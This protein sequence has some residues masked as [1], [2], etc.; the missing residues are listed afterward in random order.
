MKNIILI[1]ALAFSFFNASAQHRKILLLHGNLHPGNGEVLPSAAVG[2]KDGKII[3]LKNSLAFTYDKADWDT[4][5]DLNGKHL[6]PGFVAPN[7]TLGITEI[8]AV[9]STRDF[10]EVGQFNP[11]IRSQVA[12]NVESDVIST[13]RTNGILLCQS[14]PRGGVISG[15]SSVMAMDGWNW[16]DATIGASDGIHVNWPT[17]IQRDKENLSAKE[18]SEKYQSQKAEIYAFFEAAKAYSSTKKQTTQDMRFEAMIDCFKSNKRVYFHANELQQ[19]HDIID[20]TKAFDLPFPVIIGGYDSYLVTRKLKDAK[21][22]IML[23]RTH[24]L[25]EREDDPVDLPYSIAKK[26][27]DDGVLFCIQNEGDMEAMNA[28]NIPFLAGTAKAY[29]LTEEQAVAAISYNACKIMGI[30]E[31]Y[32]SIEVG[33]SATLF[34]SEGNALDMRS[35]Q[36]VLAMINGVFMSLTNKQSELD[37]KYRNKYKRGKIKN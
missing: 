29:G 19:I 1:L 28:R 22:P 12:Y 5:I 13:V 25:P 14:T 2:I 15:T 10:D 27:Q 33:K 16:E 3:L 24:S 36:V 21:I 17:S 8:D 30:D 23:F 31:Y 37:K 9:R 6:Y 35:N 7:S 26:L 34:V 4:I 18:E 11:N 32:G 20:F